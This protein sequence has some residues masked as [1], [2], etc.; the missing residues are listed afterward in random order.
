M[1]REGP[2][3]GLVRRAR[4]PLVLKHRAVPQGTVSEVNVTVLPSGPRGVRWSR[5]FTMADDTDR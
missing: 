5:L 1:E 4:L 3:S 2:Q